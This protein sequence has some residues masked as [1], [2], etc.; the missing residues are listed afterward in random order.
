MCVHRVALEGD[1]VIRDMDASD[2]PAVGRIYEQGIMTGHATF[3]TESPS[4]E[5]WDASHLRSSRI[6]AMVDDEV[7]GWAALS[8]VSDRCV[9]AGVA[10]V[11][12]YVATARRGRGAGRALLEA[13]ISRSEAGGIWTLQAG[14][15]PENSASIA[16]HERCGFR[17]VGRRERIGQLA[18]IWRDTMLLERR[19]HVLGSGGARS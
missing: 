1:A 19:S 10:E 2:W 12:V 5:S 7:A 8:P 16:L 18:G 14:I 6:V 11:S 13:L 4:W 3:Q 9:Y 17:V 15:F